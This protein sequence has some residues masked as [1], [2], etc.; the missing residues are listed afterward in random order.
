[1]SSDA[2]AMAAG[3]FSPLVEQAI[4]LSAQWHDATYRKSRWREAAFAVPDEAVLRVPVI[5]HVTTVAL[6]VQRAGW[7]EVTVAAAFLHD[8][9]EDRNRYRQDLR[10]E[11]LSRLMGAAV[12]DR[13]M[14]VTEQK[15]D[16]DGQPRSWQAR[17]E[18]YV[19]QLRTASAGGVA[20]SL[21]DKLHNLWTMDES[22]CRGIDIFTSTPT[23][24]ALSAGPDRQRWFHRAVLE[25]SRRHDDPR[26]APL[27]QRMEAELVRFEQLVAELPG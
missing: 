27:R 4:E 12:A 3:L 11:E 24:R 6:T 21:A 9:V 13:V 10:Y 1:M 2:S 23:R 7:D 25:V 26:L 14:E 17:K 19:A 8:T 16:E 15:Y 22:L 20:I 18:G 5:A